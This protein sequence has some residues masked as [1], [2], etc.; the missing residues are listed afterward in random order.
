MRIT[1][2]N[3]Y[4]TGRKSKQHDNDYRV[5]QNPLTD[6]YASREMSYNWS[7]EKNSTWRTL[8]RPGRVRTGI[9]PQHL[10][11]QIGKMAPISKIS[12]LTPRRQEAEL[13]HDVMS[14]SCV[15]RTVPPWRCRSS[16]SA[17]K[18]L[19]HRQHL[20][21]SKCATDDSAPRQTALMDNLRKFVM[22]YRAADDRITHY[23]PPS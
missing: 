19:R 2:N 20:S 13:R 4:Q 22:A 16:T 1:G 17:P 23:H 21:S 3:P 15:R 12:I 6:R 18:A 11:E 14:N 5:Y 8:A 9:R 7:P 10:Q